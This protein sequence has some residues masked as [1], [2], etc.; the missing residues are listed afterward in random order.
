MGTVGR[1]TFLFYE[2]GGW[3]L[4]A[5]P[6]TL[7]IELDDDG[8]PTNRSLFRNRMIKAAVMLAEDWDQQGH[9]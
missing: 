9:C 5:R 4:W 6:R 8:L 1:I 3:A 2:Y 7:G